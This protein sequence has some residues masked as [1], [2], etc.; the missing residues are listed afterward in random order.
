MTQ[1]IKAGDYVYIPSYSSKVLL[2]CT[3]NS[4]KWD[5]CAEINNDL[6]IYFHNN[7]LSSDNHTQPIVW[8][9]T[10]ENKAKIE[11]FYGIELEDVPDDVK[12]FEN[13]LLELCELCSQNKQSLLGRIGMKQLKLIEMFKKRGEK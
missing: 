13:L 10:P 12:E 3:A 1:E 11:Q 7:G 6:V 2:V 8:L 4:D 9:A 5:Y